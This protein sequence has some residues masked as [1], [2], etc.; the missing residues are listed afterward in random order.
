MTSKNVRSLLLAALMAVT[1]GGCI[2]GT[3]KEAVTPPWMFDPPK[4]T[5]SAL[6]GTGEGQSIDEAKRVAL[7]NIAGKLRTTISGKVENRTTV[8]NNNVDR[9]ASTKVSEEVQKTEFKNPV[10][11]KQ[12]PSGVGTVYVL[13]KIDKFGFVQDMEQKLAQAEKE[14]KSILGGAQAMPPI[15]RFLAYKRA[16]PWLEKAVASAQV[17]NAVSE[18]DGT[19]L[20]AHEST[21]DKAQNAAQEL[22]FDI[23]SAG[24][25][26]DIAQT[27]RTY[28]NE[29]KMR[30]GKGAGSAPLVIDFTAS[31][32]TVYNAKTVKLR[33][34]LTIKDP[35]GSAVSTREYTV[36]GSSVVDHK[37]ARA[38]ALKKLADDMRE[39]GPL[40]ALGFNK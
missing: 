25:G 27:V 3:K 30:V 26:Q 9:F 12:Q 37:Q 19:R 22:S 38:S 36:A 5:S 1:L 17:L 29:T 15:E 4:D 32:D 8:A 18:F 11:E 35:K 39:A 40:E 23:Q 7:K 16:Q 6:Y 33:I 21:L 13:V 31:Q 10:I 20:R 14:L 34:A 24:D 2:P 28:L